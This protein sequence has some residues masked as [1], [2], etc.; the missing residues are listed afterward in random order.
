MTQSSKCRKQRQKEKKRE[1]VEEYAHKKAEEERD[2]ALACMRCGRGFVRQFVLQAV[3]DPCMA[4]NTSLTP[5]EKDR[6]NLW[7]SFEV[8]LSV[9]KKMKERE[10]IW[11]RNTKCKYINLQI[12]MRDGGCIISN[13]DGERI[14][15][16][17]LAWQYSKYTPDPPKT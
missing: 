9:Y 5:A 10:W 7:D 16:D 11:A 12:D 6:M 1:R 8:F 14:G 13:R 2:K 4:E 15:A 17:R 3:C